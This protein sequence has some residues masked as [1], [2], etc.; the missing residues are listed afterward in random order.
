M[1]TTRSG[2]EAKAAAARASAAASMTGAAASA[3]SLPVA[4]AAQK[5]GVAG[6]LLVNG[7]VVSRKAFMSMSAY[8]PQVSPTNSHVWC[9]ADAC[10]RTRS[11]AGGCCRPGASSWHLSCGLLLACCCG[12]GQTPC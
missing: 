1:R 4:E 11:A 12:P 9:L 5:D 8:V 7:Q 10:N 6:D 2:K 3:V